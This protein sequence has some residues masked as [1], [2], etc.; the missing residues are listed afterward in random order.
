MNL[1]K[2]STYR[3]AYLIH[4]MHVKILHK[5]HFRYLPLLLNLAMTPNALMNLLMNIPYEFTTQKFRE[6]STS[7]S[8][9]IKQGP[10]TLCDKQKQ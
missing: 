8:Q 3:Q 10:A 6:F 1:L 5:F 9:A 2:E 4:K 7:S